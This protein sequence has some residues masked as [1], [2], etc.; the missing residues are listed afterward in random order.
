M[1]VVLRPFRPD[2]VDELWARRQ[3]EIAEGSV[4]GPSSREQV[5]E[6]VAHSGTW[7]DTAAGLLFAV[8]ADGVLVGDVQARRSQTVY[9]P[10]VVEIGIDLHA[11]ADRGRGIG[12]QAVAQLTRRLFE[13]GDAHRVQLSTDV[14]NEAMRRVAELL[15]FGF[16]GILRGFMPSPEGPRDY[17]LYGMTETDYRGVSTSWTSTS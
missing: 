1:S 7:T 16:E 15:G 6:R 4:W 2:E 3:R 17:A 11:E 5:A 9:P 12:R 10:G 8:E 13:A 14:D